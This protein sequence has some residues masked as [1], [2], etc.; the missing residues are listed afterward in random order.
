MAIL[1]VST[2]FTWDLNSGKGD[3]H[4]YRILSVRMPHD[5]PPLNDPDLSPNYQSPIHN[6]ILAR[7]LTEVRDKLIA[8]GWVYPIA[9]VHRI[10]PKA[11]PSQYTD[12]RTLV[13]VTAAFLS[14][15]TDAFA[16]QYDLISE[17]DATVILEE[18]PIEVHIY[19]GSG[20]LLVNGSSAVEVT[21][22]PATFFFYQPRDGIVFGGSSPVAAPFHIHRASGGVVFGSH[23]SMSPPPRGGSPLHLTFGGHYAFA[24]IVGTEELESKTLSD[25]STTA[26]G[27][28]APLE[29]EAL[30]DIIND[31]EPT[32]C[33]P[34]SQTPLLLR[35]KHNLD[36]TDRIPDFIRENDLEM[37]EIIHLQYNA[38]TDVWQGNLMLPGQGV[39]AHERWQLTF[40][41]GCVVLSEVS[42]GS[43]AWKFSMSAFYKNSLTGEDHRTRLLLYYSNDQ[44]CPGGAS[45]DFEFHFDPRA[46]Q[47]TPAAIQI[48][49]FLDGARIF[50]NK[51]WTTDASLPTLDIHVFAILDQSTIYWKYPEVRTPI[52]DPRAAP[53]GGLAERWEVV[54]PT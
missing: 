10:D 20:L 47:S 19:Q 49:V 44:V 4:W 53:P 38:I 27:L 2:T 18:D 52:S 33:C 12:V 42:D 37:P 39:N 54:E 50:K 35:M 45:V 51:F 43:T 15:A 26:M 3:Y 25:V 11:V 13:N 1:C 40:E 14:I 48:P 7:N 23:S 24:T 22:N 9:S 5:G 46:S 30:P 6:L 29:G 28:Y 34:D 41:F 17:T 21:N 8:A 36:E 32:F 31:D 16:L